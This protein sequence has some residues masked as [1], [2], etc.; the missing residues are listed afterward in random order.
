MILLTIC[1]WGYRVENIRKSPAVLT[2]SHASDH[3]TE[4]ALVQPRS[5]RFRCSLTGVSQHARSSFLCWRWTLG[6]VATLVSTRSK[7]SVWWHSHPAQNYESHF[8]LAL[9]YGY[10]ANN[11]R[12][13]QGNKEECG[14]RKKYFWHLRHVA[15][16]SFAI[17][18]SLVLL[19]SFSS[20]PF[21]LMPLS[22]DISVSFHLLLLASISFS[23]FLFSSLF[24]GISFLWH[25][26]LLTPFSC[27]HFF[28]SLCI[29]TFSILFLFTSISF[30]FLF[31]TF[32]LFHMFAIFCSSLSLDISAATRK[33]PWRS[34]CHTANRVPKTGSP[35]QR[36]HGI[37]LKPFFRV[38]SLQNEPK[39]CHRTARKRSTGQHW[40]RHRLLPI[41]FQNR[42]RARA[43]SKSFK[44]GTLKWGKQSCRVRGPPKIASWGCEN[45][46]SR[47]TSSRRK[48]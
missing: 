33:S 41:S 9:P 17:S 5:D 1:C 44:K 40:G 37:I 36:S 31:I 28:M 47:E 43:L 12:A 42:I 3:L 21:F 30:L 39:T 29:E 7:V 26:L 6:L 16:L 32:Y 11:A 34:N 18:C 45:E 38:Q 35:H 46:A 4:V 15:S 23:F 10:T 13:N 2:S 24:L 8:W 22:L 20:H 14:T 19:V 25:P 27:H 48:V